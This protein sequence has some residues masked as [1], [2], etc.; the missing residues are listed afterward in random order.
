MGKGFMKEK[1]DVWRLDDV[2]GIEFRSG[3]GVKEPY[4]KHWHEEYQFC[5]IEEGGGELT[6]RGISHNTPQISLFIVHPGEVHSNSTDIGC[7]F[8]SIY[9]QPEV[10]KKTLSN[11]DGYNERHFHFFQIQ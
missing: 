11:S 4:P 9:V 8:R 1:I 3:V 10:I 6:Y 2:E 7:S 5:F